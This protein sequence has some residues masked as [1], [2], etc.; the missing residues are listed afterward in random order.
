MREE[1]RNVLVGGINFLAHDLFDQGW[2]RP[3][4]WCL[5]P[6]TG[7]THGEALLFWTM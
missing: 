6:G 2:E 3:W 1:R 7:L 5:I 4:E